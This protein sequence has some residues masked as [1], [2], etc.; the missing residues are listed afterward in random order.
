MI[1]FHLLFYF[2]NFL[3]KFKLKKRNFLVPLWWKTFYVRKPSLIKKVKVTLSSTALDG[4]DLTGVAHTVI[5]THWVLKCYLSFPPS[6]LRLI[7]N[8]ESLN[9]F[10]K[11][12]T[13]KMCYNPIWVLIILLLYTPIWVL[14]ILFLYTPIWVL[15][16]L[17]LYT[18]S[19]IVQSITCVLNR[20]WFLS[21]R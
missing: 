7:F 1:K 14:I 9:F 21:S 18:P 2:S 17:F 20:F 6:N 16:I 8:L 4:I 10:V 15:I 19:F 11:I 5:A 13:E 3:S 12:N